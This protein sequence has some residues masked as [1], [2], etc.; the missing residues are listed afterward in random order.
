M[1][2]EE[3]LSKLKEYTQKE[4][5]YHKKAL[6]LEMEY[7]NQINKDNKFLK[8]IRGLYDNSGAIKDHG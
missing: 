7:F 8:C 1:T 4:E 6:R 2:E 5:Y 3:Y